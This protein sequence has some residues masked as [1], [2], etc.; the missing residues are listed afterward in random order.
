M[1]LAMQHKDWDTGEV[2]FIRTAPAEELQAASTNSEWI[3]FG[4]HYETIDK[5][6]VVDETAEAIIEAVD[7]GIARLQGEIERMQA[8]KNDHLMAWFPTFPQLT[9]EQ[10][11]E[12]MGNNEA[13]ACKACGGWTAFGGMS[14]H[15]N[16]TYPVA[17]RIGCN[18][19]K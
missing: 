5:I 18:C 10:A 8:V 1:R 2:K 16:A 3:G 6:R 17:G 11:R 15:A 7:K 4:S 12:I 14:Q 19:T 9:Y 13:A